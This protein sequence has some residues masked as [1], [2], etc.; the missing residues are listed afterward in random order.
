VSEHVAEVVWDRDGVEPGAD[1]SRSH[2]WRF[3]GGV[4][5]P[6]ASAPALHGDPTRVDP[7]EAFVASISSC[8]MLWFLHLAQDAGFYVRSYTDTAVGFMNRVDRGVI[9][10]TNVELHPR[11]EW[12]GDAPDDRTVAELHDESHHRCFIANSVTSNITV[13]PPSD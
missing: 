4:E 1:Y 7:E 13:H 10:I 9:A 5:V 6:A 11:I 2:V 8:H 3:D 12:E